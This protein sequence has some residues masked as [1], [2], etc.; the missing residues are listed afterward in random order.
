MLEYLAE[1][2]LTRIRSLALDVKDC[3]YFGHFH[4]DTIMRMSDLKQLDIWA[5][6][7]DHPSWNPRRHNWTSLI[8]V[9]EEARVGNPAWECPL[10]RILEKESGQEMGSIKGGALIPGWV[11]E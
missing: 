8:G 4:I 10:L 9:F 2:E 6:R 5:G 7:V 1:T 11:E 3:G